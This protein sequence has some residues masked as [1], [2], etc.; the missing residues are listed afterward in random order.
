MAKETDE[1]QSRLFAAQDRD[2]TKMRGEKNARG[3]INAE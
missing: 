2:G 1:H 3:M